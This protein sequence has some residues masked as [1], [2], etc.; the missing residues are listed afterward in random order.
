MKNS[1]AFT[2][3]ELLVVVLIIGI[4]AAVALPQYKKAVYKSRYA[5]LKNVT[6]SIAM[7]QEVY[8]LGHSQY[9]TKFEELDIDMPGGYTD[10]SKEKGFVWYQ[11]DWGNCSMSTTLAE[12]Y[13]TKTDM[14]YQHRYNGTRNCIVNHTGDLTDFRNTICKAETNRSTNSGGGGESG[15]LSYR[16]P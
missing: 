12:C 3:I 11:Y 14:G 10:L 6:D 15:Y 2:L 8:Y 7:A 13:N 4:L 9:A 1:R 5:T 16:Y